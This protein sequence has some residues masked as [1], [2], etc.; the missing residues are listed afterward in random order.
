MNPSRKKM[1]SPNLIVKFVLGAKGITAVKICATSKKTQ[2]ITWEIE[3]SS[4]FHRI[5]KL[6]DTWMA[7]YS[8]GQ[9][10]TVDLP[11]V[12]DGLP[13][14]TLHVLT[15]L[16]SIPRGVSLTYQELAEIAGTPKGARAVGNACGRN[17]CPLIVP[18]HRVLA[19]KGIGGFSVGVDIKKDLLAFEGIT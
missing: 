2:G 12:L 3:G 14:F 6:I 1:L 9:Q 4:K 18:C 19:S 13:P 8:K 10:P 11:I 5:E 16:R 15:I 17:P 7:A